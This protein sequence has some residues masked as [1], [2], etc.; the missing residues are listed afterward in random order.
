MLW[1]NATH[2]YKKVITLDPVGMKYF[3][4]T[5]PGATLTIPANISGNMNMTILTKWR[6]GL[7]VPCGSGKRVI[8][9]HLGSTNEFLQGCGVCFVGKKDSGDDHNE[10][11]GTHF[12]EWWEQTVLP[13]L[14]S[15]SVTVIDNAK[16]HSRQTDDSKVPT[17]SWKKLQIQKWLR[18]KGEVFNEK[19][20][21]V[22]RFYYNCQRRYWFLS[23]T[24]WKQLQKVIAGYLERILQYFV[25]SELNLIEL[26]LAQTKNEV[27]RN[28]VKF[29]I[30]P[31]KGL[32]LTTLG[33][34]EMLLNMY[35]NLKMLSVG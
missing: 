11:D 20:T 35:I 14:L 2:I 10:M 5:K 21:T 18:K 24:S 8:V 12:E 9:Y 13:K 27:A 17:T 1:H 26:I 31:V 30:T 19:D 23:D 16:Y 6:G 34:W 3:T 32:M 7:N 33:N 22:R 25:Y 28:N 29:N 15:K 4:R